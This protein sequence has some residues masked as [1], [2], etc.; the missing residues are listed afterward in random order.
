MALIACSELRQPLCCVLCFVFGDFTGRHTVQTDT[1]CPGYEQPQIADLS[2]ILAEELTTGSERGIWASL[3]NVAVYAELQRM[4]RSVICGAIAAGY[5][6][7]SRAHS[8]LIAAR[9]RRR[10][11]SGVI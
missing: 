4:Q 7:A 9:R 10:A 2:G 1:R 3:L 8:S 5:S 11:S 6:S